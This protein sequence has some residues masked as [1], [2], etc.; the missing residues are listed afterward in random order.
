MSFLGN[1]NFQGGMGLWRAFNQAASVATAIGNDG[2]AFSGQNFLRFQ[3]SKKG[4]SVAAD[5]SP[6]NQFLETWASDNTSVGGIVYPSALCAQ[7]FIRS[8]PGLGEVSG[9]LAWWQLGLPNGKT[10][11]PNIQFTVGDSWTPIFL[12][13]DLDQ[14]V[15]P[16]VR[17]ELYLDTLNTA[18]DIGAVLVT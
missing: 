5:F 13:I 12:F 10:N 11:N 18:L 9:T 17:L 16:K 8:R 15:I 1:A 4:S 7:A 2:S 6:Q 3:T 14:S